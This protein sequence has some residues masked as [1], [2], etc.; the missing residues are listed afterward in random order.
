[1]QPFDIVHILWLRPDRDGIDGKID[2]VGEYGR[3]LIEYLTQ[4]RNLPV[5]PLADDSDRDLMRENIEGFGD[6]SNESSK[7]GDAVILR[8]YGAAHRSLEIY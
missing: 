1:M 7:E 2:H 5:Y 3:H 6:M 4:V 8:F